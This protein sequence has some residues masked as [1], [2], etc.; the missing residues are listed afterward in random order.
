MSQNSVLMKFGCLVETREFF[1]DNQKLLCK[2]S[3]GFWDMGAYVH[4]HVYAERGELNVSQCF[5]GPEIFIINNRLC[6]TSLFFY[7]SHISIKR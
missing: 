5:W 1:N 7:M 4:V 3:Q 6:K 2:I